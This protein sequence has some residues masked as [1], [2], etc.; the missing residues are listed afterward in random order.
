M[1][2]HQGLMPSGTTASAGKAVAEGAEVGVGSGVLVGSSGVA[3]GMM[4]FVAGICVG[5]SVAGFN[6]GMDEQPVPDTVI[7]RTQIA[8]VKVLILYGCNILNNSFKIDC[9]D[10]N[11]PKKWVSMYTIQ[12]PVCL[13]PS[14]RFALLY[15]SSSNEEGIKFL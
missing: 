13:F 7:S 10:Y 5:V 3:D 9:I 8:R 14:S 15:L 12:E 6:D 11:I 4:V 2:R 1:G